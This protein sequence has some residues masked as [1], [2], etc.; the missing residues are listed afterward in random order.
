MI[1]FVVFEYGGEI[2]KWVLN[3]RNEKYI[4]IYKLYL[5]YV[6]NNNYFIN[7]NLLFSF[8]FGYL[9]DDLK[10]KVV[11]YKINFRSMMVS[12][13]VGLGYDFCI[14]NDIFLNLFNVKYY[15]YGMNIYMSSI[16]FLEVEKVDMLKWD[17]GISNVLCYRFILDFMGKF[18]VGYD[19]CLL[20][21]SEF[22]GDGYIVVFFGNLFF[23]CNISV[24][25]GFFL[26]CIGKDVSNL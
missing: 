12:W 3:V 22:L 26:D 25:L 2:G 15:M 19:V 20:V 17:F 8:V 7:L 14:D 21:E 23:E 10:N 24:N 1:Y 18:L 13:I 16:M 6:I 5:N 4:I 9:K 11:G